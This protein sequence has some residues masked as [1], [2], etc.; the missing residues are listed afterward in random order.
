MQQTCAGFPSSDLE[1]TT[2]TNWPYR[3]EVHKRSGGKNS[4]NVGSSNK[5]QNEE[6]SRGE[7]RTTAYW[8]TSAGKRWR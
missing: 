6:I 1:Q 7:L 3:T 2:S 8:I 4:R 5:I